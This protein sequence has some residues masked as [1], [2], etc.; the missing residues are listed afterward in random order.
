[1]NPTPPTP[2]EEAPRELD[3][4]YA[5]RLADLNAAQ[6]FGP[7]DAPDEQPA[8]D[9]P[10]PPPTTEPTSTPEPATAAPAAEDPIQVARREAR[11]E[12]DREWKAKLDGTHGNVKQW[13]AAAEAERAR[14]EQLAARL[15]EA[16][17]AREAEYQ[18]L[19][20]GAQNDTERRY[21]Q[22]RANVEKK[23]RD[24]ARREAEIATQQRAAQA[25]AQVAAQAEDQQI[26]GLFHESLTS[27]IDHEAQARGLPAEVV[28]EIREDLVNSPQF[29][30]LAEA[31]P[32]HALRYWGQTGKWLAQRIE[33]AGER[34]A[35]QRAAAEAEAAQANRQ[36]DAQTGRF[37]AGQP[38]ATGA[39]ERP[40]LNQFK[41]TR[42][43]GGDPDAMLAELNRAQ[44]IVVAG[45]A[46]D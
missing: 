6:G 9:E 33:R 28:A 37:A 17:K 45:R 13:Q 23:E 20:D 24:L 21:W 32:Q 10:A 46:R 26:R 1:M 3:A 30:V 27:F 22:D 19:I 43:K 35:A 14:A 7:A 40:D 18:Q 44:G 11:A 25:Q 29:A 15:A 34:H 36:R 4:D 31:P 42:T 38:G 41:S 12:A 2:A 16:D 8:P 5:A 39:G